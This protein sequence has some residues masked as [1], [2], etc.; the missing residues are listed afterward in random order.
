MVQ[1]HYDRPPVTTPPTPAGFTGGQVVVASYASYAEAERAVDYLSDQKFPVGRTAIVGRGL[2]SFEQVT[3]RLTIWRSAAQGAV[4]GAI[5]GALF[6]W[7]FGLFDWVN[8]LISSLLLALYGAIFGA[9][10]GA[11]LGMLGHALTGG[12]RDFSSIAGM[13]ADSYDVLVDAEVAAQAVQLL[14]TP[15]APGRGRAGGQL[16]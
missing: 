5:L 16:Q 15:T 10:V 1:P 6:G 3:G 2:S 7:L 14:D 13:R 4:S 9:V 8:P 11:L 12:R